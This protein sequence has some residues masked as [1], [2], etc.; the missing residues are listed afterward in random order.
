MEVNLAYA[1][2]LILSSSAIA[3]AVAGIFVLLGKKADSKARAKER[4][5]AKEDQKDIDLVENVK[6]LITL[7]GKLHKGLS[8]FLFDRI[9]YLCLRYISEKCIT[10]EELKDLLELFRVYE[11]DLDGNGTLG[12]FVA[13]AKALPIVPI[14]AHRNNDAEYF[15]DKEKQQEPA[16]RPT[17]LAVDD[18]HVWLTK[19]KQALGSAKYDIYTTTNPA[20]VQAMLRQI[21]PQ[22]IILDCH[23]DNMSGFDVIKVIREQKAFHNTPIIMLTGDNTD[24]TWKA[25]VSMDVSEFLTKPFKPAQLREAVSHYLS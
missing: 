12:T 8:A 19:I 23:M 9:K 7:V 20:E 4:Q 14:K 3:S 13:Q 15:V 24:E 2:P 18:S 6:N 16:E 21:S 11:K 25:A 10:G 5:E 17:I 22:L 1:L